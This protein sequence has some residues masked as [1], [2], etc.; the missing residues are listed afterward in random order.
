LIPE[1]WLGQ[2]F[3]LARESGLGPEFERGQWTVLFYHRGCPKCEVT[4][5]GLAGQ[6]KRGVVIEVDAGEAKT[7]ATAPPHVPSGWL[8]RE[9]DAS[10]TWLVETPAVIEL[11]NGVVQ[12]VR[13]T[14]EEG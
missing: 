2:T 10:K 7:N 9:L 8:H 4:L 6:D 14:A 3:P 5:R 13:R 11:T 1:D 12:A